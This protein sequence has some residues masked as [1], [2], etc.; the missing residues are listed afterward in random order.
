MDSL[1]ILDVLNQFAEKYGFQSDDTAIISG[2]DPTA[3]YRLAIVLRYMGVQ[4]VRV[5]NGGFKAW[6]SANYPVETKSNP[7]PKATIFWSANPE[8]AATD[9]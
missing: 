2:E 1:A 7:P 9:R 3:S 5:L 6:K 4:D 8:V